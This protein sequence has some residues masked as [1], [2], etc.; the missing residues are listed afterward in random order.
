M[1][2]SS[3]GGDADRFGEMDF[4][5]FLISLASNVSIHL[6]PS[7]KAYDVALAKQTID[8][9]EMLEAKTAGN[10]TE[11]EDKLLGGLLY[12]TR[13]AYCDAVKK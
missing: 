5:T 10:L 1:A 7:H 6:D 2:A 8:I 12:Q 11:E 4:S 3:G 13:V 9:L